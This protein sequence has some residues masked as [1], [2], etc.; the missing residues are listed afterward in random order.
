MGNTSSIMSNMMSVENLK[1]ADEFAAPGTLKHFLLRM[2]FMP[3]N[4]LV[5]EHILRNIIKEHG[6]MELQIERLEFENKS[7]RKENA[8]TAEQDPTR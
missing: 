6:E 4:E 7:L 1:L 2:G 5:A 3:D 8:R